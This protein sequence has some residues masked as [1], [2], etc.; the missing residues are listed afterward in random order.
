M[1]TTI[2]AALLA[3]AAAMP[4]GDALAQAAN[5]RNTLVVLRET[6]AFYS[7]LADFAFAMQGLGSGAISLHGTPEQRQQ[8]L[9]RVACGDFPALLATGGR[10]GTR[11]LRRLRQPRRKAPPVAVLLGGL[12]RAF[13]NHRAF[14]GATA[15]VECA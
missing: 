3:L 12:G 1:K 10:R 4:V 5:P 13:R 9:P 8:Y 15:G 6:L 2:G 11:R 7:P 14:T